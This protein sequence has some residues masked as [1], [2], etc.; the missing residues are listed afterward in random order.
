[1]KRRAICTRIAL[2]FSAFGVVVAGEN[3]VPAQGVSTQ[4]KLLPN[5]TVV[6]GIEPGKTD[7]YAISLN[8]GDYVSGSIKQHGKVNVSILSTDGSLLRRFPG[9][10]EDMKRQF[11]F[12][13]EGTGSYS[14]VIAT[15][16]SSLSNTSCSSRRYCR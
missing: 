15:L 4:R 16:A 10:S 13:A 8:D 11:A 9:P 2:L 12:A 7:S 3:H 5:Q 14:I 6:Q 1:M